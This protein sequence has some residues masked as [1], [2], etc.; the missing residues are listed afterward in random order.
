M[1]RPALNHPGAIS[2]LDADASSVELRGVR[3][4]R[5]RAGAVGRPNSEWQTGLALGGD[6]RNA[7]ESWSAWFQI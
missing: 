4:E 7:G 1:F 2:V 3:R 5:R 6:A